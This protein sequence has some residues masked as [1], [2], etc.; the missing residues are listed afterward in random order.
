MSVIIVTGASRG[1]GLAT[2][3]KL[4]ADPS[5]F[6]YG[7][8]R[9]AASLETLKAKH[10]NFDYVTGD[11]ADSKTAA[12]LLD[13]VIGE[14][15]KLDAIVFNAGVLGQVDQV[16]NAS[17][18]EWKEAFDI[19]FF[20]VVD[21]SAKAIPHL[22]KSKGRIVYVSSGASTKGYLGW[23]LY[24]S[25][26]A[27][28]NHLAL[29]IAAEEPDIF[30]ISVAPGVVNTSMQD[31]IREKHAEGMGAGHSRFLDLKKNNQLL[32]PVVPGT[33][34]ANLALKGEGSDLRGA[35]VRYND[36]LLEQ[37]S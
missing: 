9:S 32:D 29:S 22:R 23:G 7:V 28:I 4:L 8:S 35:Y 14:Q 30:T 37:Y 16:A 10:A 36:P 33:V 12:T 1:I 5:T 27:A 6:V 18:E 31:D 11:V 20:S 3:Q 25:T 17:V 24:G 19:N 13:K 34:L 21:L 2:V 15:G 26:K